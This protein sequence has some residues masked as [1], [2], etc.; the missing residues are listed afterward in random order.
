MDIEQD[1][2]ADE[3]LM[4]RLRGGDDAALAVLMQRWEVPIKRFIF[5][6]VGNSAEADDLAHEVFARV[7]LKRESYREGSRFSSWVFA[8]AA[9]QAKNRLRWWKR[10]PTLSLNAWLESGGDVEDDTAASASSAPGREMDERTAAVQKAVSDLPLD[11]RTAIVLFEYE[12]KSM[13]EI[14][15]IAGCSAKA[16]ENRLYRARRQLRRALEGCGSP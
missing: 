12:E 3:S 9:N 7:F 2:P 1:P 8:I 15:G 14:A 10:R 11:Q 6:L 13:A 16:V 4:A 5:R